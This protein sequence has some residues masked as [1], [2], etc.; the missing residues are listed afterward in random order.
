M[1]TTQNAQWRGVFFSGSNDS[2]LSAMSSFP[3]DLSGDFY[4]DGVSREIDSISLFGSRSGF[5]TNFLE[6]TPFNVFNGIADSRNFRMIVGVPNRFPVNEDIPAPTG[7]T[8]SGDTFS[9]DDTTG[10]Y[11]ATFFDGVDYGYDTSLGT[12]HSAAIDDPTDNIRAR[13]T[14]EAN[15]GGDRGPWSE[16]FTFSNGV[17]TGTTPL[18]EAPTIVFPSLRV[19]YSFADDADLTAEVRAYLD[20][21]ATEFD[22]SARFYPVQFTDEIQTEPVIISLSSGTPDASVDMGAPFLSA[23]GVSGLPNA[24]VEMAKPTAIPQINESAGEPEALVNL[25]APLLNQTIAAGEP[26][27]LIDLRSGLRINLNIRSGEPDAKVDMRAPRMSILTAAG[28][29]VDRVNMRP[30][31]IRISDRAGRPRVRINMARLLL[32]W[33]RG[34]SG[35]PDI[36]VEMAEAKN[37]PVINTLAFPPEI[38]V[39]MAPPPLRITPSSG[40]PAAA[41][42]MP[43]PNIRFDDISTGVPTVT[44][45]LIGGVNESVFRFVPDYSILARREVNIQLPR[46]VNEVEGGQ[47]VLTGLPNGLTYDADTHSLTGTTDVNAGDYEISMQYIG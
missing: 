11:Y 10:S 9:S 41:V 27:I 46:V 3:I 45:D 18:P 39:N 23:R 40:V 30:G 44:M 14:T 42:D 34:S 33:P 26:E 35:V 7:L 21:L 4:T 31:P 22:N 13:F 36:E 32:L 28:T 12:T 47:Y 37:I 2:I 15:D 24:S 5:G 43:F 17:V 29:P 25:G 20:F 16:V 19:P 1:P 8:Q 6:V 38:N